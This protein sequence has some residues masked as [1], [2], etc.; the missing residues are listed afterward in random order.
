MP[1]LTEEL[2][3]TAT[4]TDSQIDRNKPTEVHAPLYHDKPDAHPT[5]QSKRSPYWQPVDDQS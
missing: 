4:E 2:P 3:A 1:V 5:P